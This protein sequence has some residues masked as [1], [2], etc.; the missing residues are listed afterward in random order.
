MLGMAAW[1]PA[2][3]GGSLA[4]VAM[5]AIVPFALTL[6]VIVAHF[7]T[8]LHLSRPASLRR[9]LLHQALTWGLLL[10]FYGVAVALAPRALEWLR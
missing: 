6:R 9:A 2:P 10:G 3:D 8:V 1:A 4:P 5:V 7:E